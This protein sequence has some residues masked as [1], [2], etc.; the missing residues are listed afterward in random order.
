M[1]GVIRN[2]RP[3][4][5]IHSYTKYHLFIDKELPSNCKL[6]HTRLVEIGIFYFEIKTTV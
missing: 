1:G 6:K 3:Q 2:D 4:C 5:I